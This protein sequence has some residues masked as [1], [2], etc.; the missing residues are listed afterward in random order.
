M[1]YGHLDA[2]WLDSP[3]EGGWA[4]ADIA[5]FH[6]NWLPATYGT[7]AAFNAKNSTAYTSFSQVPA[8]LP[9]APLDGV[10]QAFRQWSVQDTYDRL[11]AA[12]R[13]VSNG[14]LFYYFGGHV[15][16]APQLGNLPDIFFNLARKYH[17]TVIEDAAN[18]AGLSLLFGSLARAYGVPVAQEWTALRHRRPDP[19][20]GGAL[21][22]DYA[23]TLP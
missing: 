16:N 7:I 21:A 15:G 23:M 22:V 3:G 6:N 9:G 13:K 12:V 10:Y 17:A 5:Y 20:R 1:D 8:A 2:Q 18:S 11:T 14:P 4:P 19:A